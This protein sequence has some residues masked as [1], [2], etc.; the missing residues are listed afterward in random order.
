[1]KK[2]KVRAHYHTSYEKGLLTFHVFWTMTAR[3]RPY[4]DLTKS[5]EEKMSI[6]FIRLM[7]NKEQEMAQFMSNYYDM[8]P[9]QRFTNMD[10]IC[11]IK[12]L[13]DLKEQQNIF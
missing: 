8:I 4:L 11:L 3:Q 7:S 6:E 5:V 13:R 2:V 1:M 9:E 12:E 10:R